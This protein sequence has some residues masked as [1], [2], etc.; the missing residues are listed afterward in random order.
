MGG[1][2]ALKFFRRT[3]KAALKLTMRRETTKATYKEMQKSPK[4]QKKHKL[5]C[6]CSVC[7]YEE[8]MF[9][10]RR[11]MAK[12]REN[13]RMRKKYLE[14][15]EEEQNFINAA[16]HRRQENEQNINLD[17]GQKNKVIPK[18]K[19]TSTQNIK[20]TTTKPETY[21][22]EMMDKVTT[23][24]ETL[25]TESRTTDSYTIRQ[26]EDEEPQLNE[27]QLAQLEAIERDTQQR[28]REELIWE[29][30]M[31]NRRQL[32]DSSR[33]YEQMNVSVEYEKWRR[34]NEQLQKEIERKEV[35]RKK[36]E[37]LT[38]KKREEEKEREEQEIMKWRIKESP[39]N[40]KDNEDRKQSP[41]KRSKLTPLRR[42]VTINSSDDVKRQNI[43][44]R[45][46]LHSGRNLGEA[47]R[48][49]QGENI[50]PERLERMIN[51]SLSEQPQY[52]QQYAAGY[53]EK[54]YIVEY[55]TCRG[56]G[57]TI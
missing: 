55:E 4:K 34:Q 30:E 6:S 56:E 26:D 7:E 53:T 9:W 33:L 48:R 46:E 35:L 54:D 3:V 5:D 22:T 44:A 24:F 40:N 18:K 43:A 36:E 50:L 13:E 31:R 1:S 10:Y 32:I 52:E 42:N 57:K 20:S 41:I 49:M 15:L 28:E 47:M 8:E 25:T 37:M 16:S 39:Y 45:I 21:K 2:T 17:N 23:E 11:S 51:P 38:R 29:W 19:K 12:K 27:F 14:E